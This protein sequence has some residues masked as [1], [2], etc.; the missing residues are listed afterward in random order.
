MGLAQD[1]RLSAYQDYGQLGTKENIHLVR[2]KR[3]GQIC[4]KKEMEYA[5]EN[6]VE[7]RK[8]CKAPFFPK[9]YEVVKKENKITII[10]EYISGVTLEEYMMGKSLPE[11]KAKEIACQ[12]CKALLCLHRAEPAIIYRDLKAENVMLT[13]D[14][15]IKLVDFDISR[16]FQE[17]KSRDTML[18]GTAQYA[19]PEQFGYFQSD[20]RT[21]I[22]AFGVLFNYML[23]GKFPDKHI[24][25]GKYR[26]L[27]KKCIEMEP[28]KRYQ[29]IDEILKVLDVE[30]SQDDREKVN[31]LK[32]KWWMIP[33][34]RTKTWWKMIVAILGYAFIFWMFLDIEFT[35]S[36]G[37]LYPLWVQWVRRSAT[38]IANLIF[39]FLIF[40]YKPVKFI[41]KMKRIKIGIIRITAYIVLWG[42]VFTLA[43]LPCAII[44]TIF[45]IS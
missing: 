25:E 7:F 27:I 10:E 16:E 37:D 24:A 2:D 36:N 32:D 21:D 6:I 43:I 41:K 22:Y 30:A 19:A 17:G 4:V 8:A 11:E 1:Y 35:N 33:G 40:E 20:N 34:F 12:I 38:L 18:L 29:D 14:G 9:V 28:S 26:E 13:N 15:D 3:T 42:I 23:T 45:G 39:I 5:Q 31:I 44:E